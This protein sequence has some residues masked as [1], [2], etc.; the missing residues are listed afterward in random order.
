[1]A[2]NNILT[3]TLLAISLL[4]F[5]FSSNAENKKTITLA[6][7]QMNIDAGNVS[8]LKP[9]VVGLHANYAIW[10]GFSIEGRLAYPYDGARLIDGDNEIEIDMSLISGAYIKYNAPLLA[11]LFSPYVMFGQSYAEVEI[12]AV[13]VDGVQALDNQAFSADSSA[14]G[15]GVDIKVSNKLFIGLE[16][17]NYYDEESFEITA[18]ALNINYKF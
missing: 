9:L 12:T 5:S 16:H 2:L 1:V 8:G 7:Y 4:L 15:L 11:N 3:L 17:M 13:K 6:Y 14:Y 18:T 10:N